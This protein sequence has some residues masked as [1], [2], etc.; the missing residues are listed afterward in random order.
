MAKKLNT[1]GIVFFSLVVAGLVLAVIGMC[2]PIL[3]MSYLGQTESVG[4]SHEMWDALATIKEAIN[5]LNLDVTV[6]TKTF[7]VIAFVV[8]LVGA[9]ILV[10]NAILG[11]LGKDIK[12]LGL[13]G[14]AVAI[15][16]GILVLVAGLVLAGQF[17]SYLEDAAKLGGGAGIP[18]GAEFSAGIGIWIGA[19]GGILAG[20]AGLLGALKVGQKA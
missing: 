15:V 19:I 7:T 3:T 11:L 10:V 2:T 9:G 8:T 12:I 1:L 16:G 14:G 18:T 4:M 13:V 5:T 20:V 6:P 17:A